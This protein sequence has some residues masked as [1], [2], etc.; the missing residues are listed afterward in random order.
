M[1][2]GFGYSLDIFLILIYY[3]IMKFINQG[4]Q[5]YG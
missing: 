3:L 4:Y 1:G 5:G 2:L